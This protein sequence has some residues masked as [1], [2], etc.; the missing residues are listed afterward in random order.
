MSYPVYMVHAGDV[1]PVFFSS[2]GKTNGES[3]TLT[4]LAVTDIEIFKDGSV[5]QRASDAGY[6]LLDTDG[7]DF[8]SLTGIHGFSIDTGDNTD[9]SF[10]T[11][12]AWFHV[13]VSAVTI[14]SQT[15]NFIAAAFRLMPAES[16]AGKP[17][18]DADAVAG[19]ATASTN[20]ALAFNDTAGAVPWSGIVD[21]GTAQSATGTTL[22]LRAAAAFA[23]DE[24][25]GAT[26]LITG[27]TTGVGQRRVITDYVSATDTAT[28]ATWTTTPTGT[29]TYKVFASAPGEGVAQTG[30]AY[31]IVN[32]GTHGNSA[33][34]TLIDAIEAALPSDPADASVIAGL[35]A[36][37]EAK[38]DTIDDLLDSEI[39][40][41]LAA[42]DTEIAALTV[43]VAAI[44][45]KT[46]PMTYT[47]TNYLQS[48]VKKINGT[49][50]AG[51]GGATPWGP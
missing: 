23:D 5:T 29:I 17:K 27:G 38:V 19:S 20:L 30:D 6:V 42:V 28:V 11:V 32:S 49:T 33:L 50:V 24:L 26:I 10:Y 21:Q 37:L 1:L 39:A 43:S 3:I 12:G 16:V 47:A 9:A 40:A 41:I 36:A 8:D 7:I 25:I 46:D 44:K 31:A 2:Y 4:G 34:K 45:A 13:V 14:D 18:V 15:V 35:I 51:D 22:V 48:D